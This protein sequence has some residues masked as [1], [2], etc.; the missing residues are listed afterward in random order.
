MRLG[1]GIQ[2]TVRV[3]DPPERIAEVLFGLIMVL[4]FTG[5][6]GAAEAGRE[7]VRIM[8]VGALGCNVAWG[9]IDGFL[10]VLGALAERGRTLQTYKAVRQSPDPRQGQALVAGALP[11]L[12]AEVLD[13]AELESIRQRLLALPEPTGTARTTVRDWLGALG[14]FLLVFMSTFPVTIPFMLMTDA[15]G[16]LRVSN[17]VA[18]A[19]M[20]IAGVAYGRYIGRSPL[21]MG[22]TMVALGAIMVALT[23]ALG[24]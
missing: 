9:I 22:V 15:V 19:M 23:I 4:T 13:P 11:T 14:V 20:F 18:I 16:A 5:T 17:A 24:G 3:L 10:Y 7:D 21:F 6:L 1:A 8:L 12:V 2:H